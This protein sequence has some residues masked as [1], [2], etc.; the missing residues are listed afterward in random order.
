[1]R[2]NKPSDLL[3]CKEQV[4]E[5]VAPLARHSSL[6]APG[7][8]TMAFHHPRL[9]DA[10]RHVPVPRANDILGASCQ[11][12]STSTWRRMARFSAQ[13]AARYDALKTPTT[14]VGPAHGVK[15]TVDAAQRTSSWHRERVVGEN[16][17]GYVTPTPAVTVWAASP[18]RG[19]GYPVESA[20][21][22][23][24]WTYS[25]RILWKNNSAP[26]WETLSC[27]SVGN[28]ASR[29]PVRRGPRL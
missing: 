14:H 3:L 15:G 17:D 1:V 11:L 19:T 13:S 8:R 24:A 27:R 29:R 7:L 23:S 10:W 12:N 6:S 5:L 4:A 2:C 28:R 22:T 9:N 18:G 16:R 26:M 25:L 21:M 20:C